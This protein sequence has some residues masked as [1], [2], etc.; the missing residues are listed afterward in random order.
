VSGCV[1]VCLGVCV[2]LVCV[3]VPGCVCVCLVCVCVPGCV[4]VCV[5]VCVWLKQ[6]TSAQWPDCVH[7][8]LSGGE[9][10][11]WGSSLCLGRVL[12]VT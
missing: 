11:A 6:S 8:V 3:C 4:S 10:Q 12:E 7:S 9:S 2:C 5:W 1:F